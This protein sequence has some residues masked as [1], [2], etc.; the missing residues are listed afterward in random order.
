MKENFIYCCKKYL[1]NGLV[2]P[3]KYLCRA[4]KSM[5]LITHYNKLDSIHTQH[6][7]D[8]KLIRNSQYLL[9]S[10][11]LRDLQDEKK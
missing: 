11:I 7:A 8:F 2:L 9:Y 10:H 6:I 3:V 5:K 4:L 1:K